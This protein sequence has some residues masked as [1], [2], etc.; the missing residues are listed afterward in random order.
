MNTLI[1]M[2][3]EMIPGDAQ[4]TIEGITGADDIKDVLSNLRITLVQDGYTIKVGY[5]V[6]TED[7]PATEEVD[8]STEEEKVFF[9]IG[10]SY[11]VED[12]QADTTALTEEELQE[13][14]P[15]VDIKIDEESGDI[16][17]TSPLSDALLMIFGG[18]SD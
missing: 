3:K 4:A 13:Y 2:A 8:E 5:V 15:F 17:S 11:K 10:F 9:S 14:A 18:L 16:E 7:D 1:D 12:S 6:V